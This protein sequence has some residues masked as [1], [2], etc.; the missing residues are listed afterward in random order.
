MSKGLWAAIAQTFTKLA[1]VVVG[2]ELDS[3]E[4]NLALD[5][6]LSISNT[7]QMIDDLTSH[8]TTVSTCWNKYILIKINVFMWRVLLNCIPTRINLSNHGIDIPCLFCPLCD[9]AMEDSNHVYLLCDIAVQVWNAIARW[10]DLTFRHLINIVEL[11]SWVDTVPLSSKK[12]NVLEVIILSTIWILWW[13][14]ISVLFQ[15]SNFPKC[16]IMDLIVLNSFE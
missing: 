9:N 2:L 3:W 4:S 5:D 12:R 7:R 16:L 13:L 15:A 8:V 6:T 11:M 10:V 1:E 14:K